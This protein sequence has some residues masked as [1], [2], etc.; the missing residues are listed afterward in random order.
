MTAMPAEHAITP[1]PVP[2]RAP[3]PL[4]L[5]GP[6]HQVLQAVVPSERFCDA[7]VA[8][9]VRGEH[10]AYTVLVDGRRPVA[11]YVGKFESS[12]EVGLVAFAEHVATLD[13]SRQWTVAVSSGKFAAAY[14]QFA[15][16][17]P[18]IELVLTPPFHPVMEV[19][20]RE[21]YLELQRHAPKV[22]NSTKKA[23]RNKRLLIATDGSSGY[24]GAEHRG[25]FGWLSE[26][27]EYGSGTIVSAVPVDA[28]VSAIMDAVRSQHPRR[29]LHIISDSQSAIRIFESAVA[30]ESSCPVRDLGQGLFSRLKLALEG[31]NVTIAKVKGHSGH[32]LNEGADRLSRYA[33]RSRAMGV[34]HDSAD[35]VRA[36]IAAES[37]DEWAEYLALQFSKESDDEQHEGDDA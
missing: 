24:H 15:S 23:P 17:W 22:K 8:T 18:H 13:P 25:G 12:S 7:V 20:R 36:S 28:E 26:D 11:R 9:A 35:E 37:I 32:P 21:A 10:V 14:A 31:R 34:S 2:R 3:S 27:G 29:K 1:T 5:A 16:A 4:S 33:R 19:A 30:G 6:A